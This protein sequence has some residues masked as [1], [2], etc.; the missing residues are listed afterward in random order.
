[1]V[2]FPKRTP[3]LFSAA[4]SKSAFVVLRLLL[5]VPL[6]DSASLTFSS[7]VF[8]SKG[9]EAL[10]AALTLLRSIAMFAYGSSADAAAPPS[11]RPEAAPA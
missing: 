8:F 10:G 6:R 5:I 4:F 9:F 11:P 7:S 2:L 3:F 1:M